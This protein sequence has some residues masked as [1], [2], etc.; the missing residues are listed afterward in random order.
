MNRLIMIDDQ[1]L[2]ANYG[3]IGIQKFPL[4]AAEWAELKETYFSFISFSRIQ[5][6]RVNTIALENCV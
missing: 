3:L 6:I 2:A 5:L 4:P 1:Q